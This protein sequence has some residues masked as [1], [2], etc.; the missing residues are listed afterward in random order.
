M[1]D[2]EGELAWPV[3]LLDFLAMLDEEDGC[4]DKHASLLLAYTLHKSPHQW[5]CNLL[6]DSMHS[7]EQFR[8][9][10][11]DTFHHYDSNHLDHKLLQQQK[12]PHKSPMDFWQCFHDLQFRA[13][14]S[15]MKFPYL[16]DRFKFYLNKSF[17]PKKK[18]EPKPHSAYF[19][20]GVVQSQTDM[21]TVT[22]DCLWSPHQI[23]PP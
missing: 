16:W 6:A 13:L 21:V 3:F 17:H 11:E 10:I 1:Y 19:R 14:K 12:A 23:A 4:S 15:Q 5:L 2:G 7:L 22:S 20:D 8:D 9:L 18:F